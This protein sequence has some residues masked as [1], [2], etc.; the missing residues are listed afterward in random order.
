L[1]K[2]DPRG[3]WVEGL[4]HWRE[5]DTAFISVAFTWKLREAAE[6]AEYYWQTG[7]TRVRA[8]G[9]GLFTLQRKIRDGLHFL[10]GK[11]ELGGDVPDAVARHNPMATKASE[12]CPEKCDFC[13]VPSLGGREFTYFPDFIVRPVLTDNNLSGLPIDYQNHIVDRYKG[14]G[15]RIADANSGFEPKSF[16]EDCFHRWAPINDGPWR[17]GYDATYEEKQSLDVMRLLRRHG[18]PSKKIRPYVI[19]G[20]EPFE[21]CMERI[22]KTIENGGE[23]HVQPYMKLNAEKREPFAKFDWTVQKLRDVARWANSMQWRQRTFAEY[24]RTAR[25]SPRTYYRATD[26]LFV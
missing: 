21:P 13:I 3:R 11:V 12:G 16:D 15:V 26:G 20:N 8:G 1:S 14:H 24:D 4:A 9:P 22:L 19:I 6:V 10:S 7:C 23:P 25:K 18:V 17:F 5:G 2:P